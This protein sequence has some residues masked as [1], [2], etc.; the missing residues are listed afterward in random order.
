MSITLTGLSAKQK[1]LAD[2]I[3]ACDT[4]AKVEL[5]IYSLPKKDRIQATVVLE[6]ITLAFLDEVETIDPETIK[7]IDKFRN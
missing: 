1:V 7:V 6:M 5:F 4:K 2:I 3:W